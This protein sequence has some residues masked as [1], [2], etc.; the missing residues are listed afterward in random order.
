MPSAR[1]GTGELAWVL[2]LAAAWHAGFCFHMVEPFL[3]SWERARASGNPSFS[4][5]S[6]R[7]LHLVLPL[8]F[9]FSHIG[10]PPDTPP[11]VPFLGHG[12]GKTKSLTILS[13]DSNVTFAVRLLHLLSY[14]A[15]P[16]FSMR[17]APLSPCQFFLPSLLFSL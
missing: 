5:C 4:C 17:S 14:S 10:E 2:P 12:R 8:F 16:Q 13:L 1:V 9:F 15:L 3:F 6:A 11:E 7:S